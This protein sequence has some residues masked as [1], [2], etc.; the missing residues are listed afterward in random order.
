MVQSQSTK[1][2][3]VRRSLLA[4]PLVLVLGACTYDTGSNV[5]RAGDVNQVQ[6]IDRGVVESW[7]AVTVQT[8]KPVGKFVGAGVGA[9]AG[10]DIG[11]RGA[12]GVIGAI[13]GGL[14]GGAVGNSVDEA[15]GRRQG[16]EYIVVLDNG[17][18]VSIVD[19]SDEPIPAGAPVILQY[20][21]R[22]RIRLDN[23][24]IAD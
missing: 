24:R 15:A 6:D 9:A 17:S 13:V 8:E 23:S 16:F 12:G 20:G 2:K 5:Y 3:S 1:K 4:L 14:V 19:T 22:T 18:R 10:A 7:R 21:S 11:G